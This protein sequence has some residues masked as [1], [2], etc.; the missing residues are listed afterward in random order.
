MSETYVPSLQEFRLHALQEFAYLR[1]QFGFKVTTPRVEYQNP[2]S[3]FFRHSGRFVYVEG[4]SYGY[5]LSVRLGRLGL[6]SRIQERLPLSIF[7]ELREPSLL[8]PRFPSRR[9]QLEY[10]SS[11]AVALRRCAADFLAGDLSVLPQAIQIHGERERASRAAYEKS[12]RDR[13][14]MRA[15]DAFHRAW[16]PGRRPHPSPEALTRLPRKALWEAETVA[17]HEGCFG[18]Y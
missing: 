13:A 16:A 10:I 12:I 5:S 3:V 8:E 6:F 14:F 11:A 7:I 4:E 1:S 2:C 18:L 17:S 15:S 9:G